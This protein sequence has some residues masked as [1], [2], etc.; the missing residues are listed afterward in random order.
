[1][2][3]FKVLL[4]DVRTPFGNSYPS[5]IEV[6]ILCDKVQGKSVTSEEISN[7]TVAWPVKNH[8]DEVT[9]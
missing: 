3:N 1:M 8:T 2:L 9:T 5:W 6:G 4:L 7:I